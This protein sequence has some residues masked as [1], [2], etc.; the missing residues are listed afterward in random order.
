MGDDTRARRTDGRSA[1][2]TRA[3]RNPTTGRETI[4]YVRDGGGGDDGGDG[5]VDDDAG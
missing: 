2:T 3:T 1:T 4:R 5:F